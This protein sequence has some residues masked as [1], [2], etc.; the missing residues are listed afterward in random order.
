MEEKPRGAVSPHGR[1]PVAATRVRKAVAPSVVR[2]TLPCVSRRP[3][4][5]EFDALGHRL[6]FVVEFTMDKPLVGD[7]VVAPGLADQQ[8]AVDQAGY[9]VQIVQ[10]DVAPV[11]VGEL[12]LVVDVPRGS[13]ER[14]E[15]VRVSLGV[16]ED[17]NVSPT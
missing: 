5:P 2:S 11:A 10:L 12:D 1:F 3:P 7:G 17:E 15:T 6:E 9:D 14:H 13:F 16:L 8:S 4:D